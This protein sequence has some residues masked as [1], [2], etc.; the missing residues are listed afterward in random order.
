MTLNIFRKNVILL[1]SLIYLAES[2]AFSSQE[3]SFNPQNNLQTSTSS[4]GVVRKGRMP[5]RKIGSIKPQY[6][7]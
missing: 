4:T 3:R 1:L 6:E 7:T 5:V 2:P